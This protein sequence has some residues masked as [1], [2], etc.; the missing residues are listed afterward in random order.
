MKRK[1]GLLKSQRTAFCVKNSTKQCPLPHA[2]FLYE[3]RGISVHT[4]GIFVAAL[5][6]KAHRADAVINI[7]FELDRAARKL[8]AAA[9]GGTFAGDEDLCISC[10]G[11]AGAYS[12]GI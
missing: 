9:L 8:F 6:R 3:K 5:A 12:L 10:G 7:G 1:S 4:A 2:V 11:C